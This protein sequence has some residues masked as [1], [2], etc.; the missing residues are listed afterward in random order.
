LRHLLSKAKRSKEPLDFIL[1]AIR[2]LLLLGP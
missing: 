1:V 2:K